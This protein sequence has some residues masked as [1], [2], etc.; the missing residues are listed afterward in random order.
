MNHKREFV[1]SN[2]RTIHTNK[3]ERLWRSL[4]ST[5]KKNLVLEDIVTAVKEFEHFYN[6]KSKTT[7]ARYDLLI[8]AIKSF[9]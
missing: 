2:D 1:D 3:I 6:L 7:S 9:L 5:L 8:E 4:K